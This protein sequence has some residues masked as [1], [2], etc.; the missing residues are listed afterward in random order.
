MGRP[1]KERVEDEV[2]E[3]AFGSNNFELFESTLRS[4]LDGDVLGQVGVPKGH[5]CG[6][7][8]LD[9]ML[10]V[11]FPQ[12]FIHE[13]YALNAVGKTTLALEILGQAQKAGCRVAYLD[14]EGTLNQTLVNSIRSLDPKKLD[15]FGNPLWIYK[16]GLIKAKDSDD[17]K[18]MTGEEAFKFIITFCSMFRDSYIVIDSVDSIIPSN[19]LE[20]KD[21]G[22]ATMGSLG[23]LMSDGIR[24]LHGIC[25]KNNTT[26]IFI[27]QV[28]DS[29]K[30][31]G[32]PETTPGGK[33]LAFY[34]F[35]R[36]KLSRQG[37][38]ANV[39]DD[40]GKVIGHVVKAEPIKNKLPSTQ[41]E[42]EFVILY[43]KGI[44]REQEIIDL[45]VMYGILKPYVDDK[46]KEFKTFLNIAGN[47]VKAS[48]ASIFLQENPPICEQVTA[49]VK[50][51]LEL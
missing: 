48:H 24:R 26:A 28:R 46:G 23:K 40:D 29:L 32:A 2:P 1:P 12:G 13:I 49:E 35:S 51:I 42:V 43:G 27:N 31:F 39:V 5:G 19:I 3:G 44:N 14:L 22:D 38:A 25:K 47:K 33:A 18:V 10:S 8:K 7:L 34:A 45:G 41:N 15:E 4:E 21:V 50:K 6:S 36:V 30:M 20:G 11:A 17:V 16:E 9:M 37:K